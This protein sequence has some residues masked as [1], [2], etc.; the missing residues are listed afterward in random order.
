MMVDGK[1][2]GHTFSQPVVLVAA[3]AALEN[4][5]VVS[6]D[7]REFVAAGVPVFDPFPRQ[8]RSIA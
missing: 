1:K 6:R 8:L 4:L 5:V 2:R 7:P 3:I